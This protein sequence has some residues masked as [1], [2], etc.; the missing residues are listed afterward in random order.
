MGVEALRENLASTKERAEAKIATV[1]AKCEEIRARL[2]AE[3]DEKI[4]VLERERENNI[5]Y[6]MGAVRTLESALRAAEG[7]CE[8][9]RCTGFTKKEN[10]LTTL[11]EVDARVTRGSDYPKCL[12]CQTNIYSLAHSTKLCDHHPAHA[13]CATARAKEQSKKE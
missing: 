5:S 13:A 1:N 4:D 7:R 12:I 9:A 11:G 6:T 3:F 2:K 8:H 10:R